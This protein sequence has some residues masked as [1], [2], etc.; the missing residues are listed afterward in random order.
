MT[1]DSPPF[2]RTVDTPRIVDSAGNW[3]AGLSCQPSSRSAFSCENP[4]G[5]RTASHN[6]IEAQVDLVVPETVS[7]F[8]FLLYARPLIPQKGNLTLGNGKCPNSSNGKKES[9]KWLKV[10]AQPIKKRLNA[11]APGAHLKN[12]DVHRLMSLCIFLSEANMAPSPFA[13]YLKRMSSKILNI[14]RISASSIVAG[15]LSL[16]SYPVLQLKRRF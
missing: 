1:Q 12:K 5:F 4:L 7:I 9:K 16:F 8:H 6:T 14:M 13:A 11:A 15:M 2:V 10:F 3:S